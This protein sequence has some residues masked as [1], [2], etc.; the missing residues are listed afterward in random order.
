MFGIALLPSVDVLQKNVDFFFLIKNKCPKISQSANF[1]VLTFFFIDTPSETQR[2]HYSGCMVVGFCLLRVSNFLLLARP[3]I[4]LS[5][6]NRLQKAAQPKDPVW[7][8]T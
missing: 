3:L 6:E 5:I 2:I 8:K 4:F 7:Q 1:G